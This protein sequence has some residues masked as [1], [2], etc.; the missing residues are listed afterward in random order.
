MKASG[1]HRF[2]FL[3]LFAASSTAAAIVI[4]ADVDDSKYRV[5]ASAF[6]ALADMPG[7]G[8]GVLI[9][10]QWIITAAHAITWQADIKRVTLN[11]KPRD[12]ERVVIHPGYKKPPHRLVQRA[13]ETWDWTLFAT[14]L[15][16]SDDVA[17]LKLAHAVTDVSPVAIFNG[18]DEFGRTISILGKGATGNGETGYDPHGS[19]RTRLRQAYNK[20]SSADGRWFCYVFDKPASA[21]PL[22]GGSGSGDSGGPILVQGEKGWE[23]AGLTSWVAPQGTTKAPPGQYG[24]ASCNV[25]LGHYRQWI[26]DNFSADAHNTR[27]SGALGAAFVISGPGPTWPGSSPQRR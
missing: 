22:E 10:P 13:L 18:D 3:I 9:A 6:P 15:S 20:V 17:L 4:R 24:Q 23:L 2:L 5:P 7:E 14:L 27:R 19:H 21:L 8:H 26:E 25:R 16:S 11:G 12:V 1:M